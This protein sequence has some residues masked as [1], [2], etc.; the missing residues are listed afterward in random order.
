VLDTA[1]VLEQGD[2]SICIKCIF[3]LIASQ[4]NINEARGRSSVLAKRHDSQSHHKNINGVLRK[5]TRPM[6]AA[7]RAVGANCLDLLNG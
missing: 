5:L 2:I 3:S 6:R 7:S 4:V 1:G